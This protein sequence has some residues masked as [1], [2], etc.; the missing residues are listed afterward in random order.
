MIYNS[1][2]IMNNFIA[3]SF[4]NEGNKMIN[5]VFNPD[6]NIFTEAIS[7]KGIKEK[8][9]KFFKWL[10]DKIKQAGLYVYNSIKKIIDNF[11]NKKLNLN[12]ADKEENNINKDDIENDD[13]YI[14]IDTIDMDKVKKLF[15]KINSNI[16][17]DIEDATEMSDTHISQVKKKV[18]GIILNLNHNSD[19]NQLNSALDELKKYLD[20]INKIISDDEE[21]ISNIV[22][23]AE[24]GTTISDIK[25]EYS[26]FN[27]DGSIKE[28]YKKSL[29][30]KKDTATD[31]SEKIKNEAIDM[32]NQI[33][34][35]I[36]DNYQIL[37][38]DISKYQSLTTS[39]S[40]MIDMLSQKINSI[41]DKV[42][43]EA[44]NSGKKVVENMMKQTNT[45]ANIG[46]EINNINANNA[47]KIIKNAETICNE[48]A[49]KVSKASNK[50]RLMNIAISDVKSKEDTA[51]YINA[52]DRT[53]IQKLCRPDFSLKEFAM[54]RYVELY[55]ETTA[56]KS[57]IG[58]EMYKNKR[59]LPS[60][61]SMLDRV[62]EKCNKIL[63][64]RN[65]IEI[66]RL[67]LLLNAVENTRIQEMFKNEY[68]EMT[69][70]SKN[71]SYIN[72]IQNTFNEISFI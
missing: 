38:K 51:D 37:S 23:S 15:T 64:S 40:D 18:N 17:F 48:I 14:E 33:N 8:V 7:F 59:F 21:L 57:T 25:N 42:N 39:V 49:S 31:I 72:Y 29:K 68:D 5:N 45:V 46:N 34:K 4:Y 2:R 56:A 58:F 62:I 63:R 16:S 20:Q 12:N 71:E 66:G 47:A 65:K 61:M 10:I 43:T 36:N 70:K 30:I 28:E 24:I 3:E 11:K 44:V 67:I 55:N 9:I 22:K 41:D 52:L 1:N 35:S 69:G 27:N 50:D 60:Y 19:L 53:K 13:E 32:S 54:L 6:T 26:V